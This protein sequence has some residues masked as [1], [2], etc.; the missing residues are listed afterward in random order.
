MNKTTPPYWD[1]EA[2]DTLFKVVVPIYNPKTQQY[3]IEMAALL[4]RPAGGQVM[5][6]AI[7]KATAHMD[8]PSKTPPS[9][10]VRYYW[11]T[12]LF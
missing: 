2:A 1:T 7:A 8:T 5:P 11:T 3:L 12:L 4:V 9:N 10:A 6:L